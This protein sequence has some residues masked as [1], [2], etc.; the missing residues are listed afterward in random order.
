MLVKEFTYNFA[1]TRVVQVAQPFRSR[2]FQEHVQIT[3]LEGAPL[4]SATNSKRK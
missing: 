4:I 3:F 1:A 2:S